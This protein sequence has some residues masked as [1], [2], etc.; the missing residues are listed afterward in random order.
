[1]K[2][3]TPEIINAFKVPFPNLLL[4]FDINYNH[5]KHNYSAGSINTARSFEKS[6]QAILNFN[7]SDYLFGNFAP[8]QR[9]RVS[10]G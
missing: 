4:I 8:K 3:L 2:I 9:L 1:V 5:G 7:D 6:A 10:N